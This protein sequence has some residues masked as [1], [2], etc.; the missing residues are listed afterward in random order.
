MVRKLVGFVFELRL[1]N[2]H[3]PQMCKILEFF[4]VRILR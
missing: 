1:Y 2:V 3:S 4:I